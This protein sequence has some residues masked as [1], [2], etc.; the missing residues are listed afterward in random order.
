[1]NVR[2][3]N[4]SKRMEGQQR[5][6]VLQRKD[7]APCPLG[8]VGNLQF[9]VEQG[10]T[11]PARS[12]RV[13]LWEKRRTLADNAFFRTCTSS[14]AR[15]QREDLI[16]V[17]MNS[18]LIGSLLG[19]LTAPTT[20]LQ[21]QARIAQALRGLNI[22]A[23][24]SLYSLKGAMY[25]LNTY[26]DELK[27]FDIVALSRAVLSHGKAREDVLNRI[28]THPYDALR[29]RSDWALMDVEKA[30]THQIFRRYVH[31]PLRHVVD[32][33]NV[34]RVDGQ[35][36]CAQ[37]IRISNNSAT[38]EAYFRRLPADEFKKMLRAL[39]PGSPDHA[40]RA[41]DDIIAHSP[42]QARAKQQALASMDSV[43]SALSHEFHERVDSYMNMAETNLT[44][45]LGMG[46]QDSVC[47]CLRQLSVRVNEAFATY[48][49][50]PDLVDQRVR[51]LIDQ[52]M[53]QLRDHQAN[54]VGPLN[55]N[56]LSRLDDGMR[57]NLGAAFPV[58]RSFGLEVESELY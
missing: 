58:L 48:G 15:A 32:L 40:R 33:L 17:R 13:L 41:L 1:M 27:E 51:E 31:E 28:S 55:G 14:H 16:Q 47:D 4:A 25:C 23:T 38:L 34:R 18:H 19:S 29:A 21:G 42:D 36:L 56:S 57:A 5:E 8:T 46:H 12:V 53:D 54:P 22:P 37:L 7:L 10:G 2:S 35:K 26:L 43:R 52:S 3:H 50:L 30:V 20:D 44:M 24:G 6:L 11:A 45:S 9:N 39:L 49:A